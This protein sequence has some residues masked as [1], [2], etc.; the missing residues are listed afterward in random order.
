MVDASG[1]VTP[2]RDVDRGHAL[3]LGSRWRELS[4]S[5]RFSAM[6]TAFASL[7]AKESALFAAIAEGM[8]SPGCG[9]LHELVEPSRSMSAV[10][11]S[12]VKKGLVDSN[13]DDNGAPSA[14]CWVSLTD[15]GQALA[16]PAAPSPILPGEIAAPAPL[17]PL[18]AAPSLPVWQAQS[19]QQPQQGEDNCPG[20]VIVDIEDAQA[21]AVHIAEHLQYD[22]EASYAFWEPLLHRLNSSIRHAE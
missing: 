5:P 6:R 14:C 19:Q 18:A 16:A 11:G 7:T 12:L 3:P 8:D 21:L 13:R 10:L 4:T 15:A 2:G 17:P 1:T 22:D 20:V 9:W